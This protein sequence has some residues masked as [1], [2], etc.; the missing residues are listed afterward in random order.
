M[1]R[2]PPASWSTPA[3]S[4][5]LTFKGQERDKAAFLKKLVEFFQARKTPCYIDGDAQAIITLD[6]PRNKLAL[7]PNIQ[8]NMECEASDFGLEMNTQTEQ[9]ASVSAP[10]A[11][12]SGHDDRSNHS[13]APL[14]LQTKY[15]AMVAFDSQTSPSAYVLGRSLGEGT[16][17]TVCSATSK[18]D[19]SVVAL[20]FF[21]ETSWQAEIS[22]E[23]AVCEMLMVGEPG[24][25]H[26]VKLLDVFRNSANTVLALEHSGRTMK[27]AI[28][29]GLFR[30]ASGFSIRDAI[31]LAANVIQQLAAGLRHIHTNGII[32]SDL[33]YNNILLDEKNHVRY[34]DFGSA[35]FEHL[36]PAHSALEAVE[37][38]FPVTTLCFRAP[39]ILLGGPFGMP[40]DVW[41]VGCLVY[42][43]LTGDLPWRGHSQVDLLQ[44]MFIALGSPVENGWREA[45]GY[46]NYSTLCKG[47]RRQYIG[48]HVPFAFGDLMDSMLALDPA[49]RLNAHAVYAA[50]ARARVEDVEQ[51]CSADGA[52]V[53]FRQRRKASLHVIQEGS[54][55]RLALKLGFDAQA[56]LRDGVSVLRNQIL[57]AD[58]LAQAV[59]AAIRVRATSSGS[60][61]NE[62]IFLRPGSNDDQKVLFSLIN[63]YA[64]FL[65]ALLGS[66]KLP[67]SDGSPYQHHNQLQIAIKRA[68]FAGYAP[69]EKMANPGLGHIDQ[70]VKRQFEGCACA[71]YSCL[72][73]I[74]LQ[75]KTMNEDAGNLYVSKGSHK[76]LERA[77]AS[78]EGDIGWSPSILAK[79]GISCAAPLTPVLLNPGQAV[80]MQ[81]QTVHG[82]G[83]N[84]TD[85]DRIQIYFRVTADGR[86]SGCKIHYPAAMRNVSLELP[87]LVAAVAKKRRIG[88]M[89]A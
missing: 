49:R 11:Q 9:A 17:G 13:G 14:S 59:D 32:H 76:E 15:S 55:T 65:T 78:T 1:S 46:P 88:V 89:V 54:F 18:H 44:R 33:S 5:R 21:R 28:A 41:S 47:R 51:H 31:W 7:K 77:F 26:I 64:Q 63:K 38:G 6:S 40:C 12:A 48:E 73:G 34:A 71:N 8:R 57:S 74:C 37:G 10:V 58:E 81:Y 52:K 16:F 36:R 70:S 68:G 25:Q 84:N 66:V 45:Q 39:E 80:L 50:A 86:P 62:F 72:L 30:E 60:I 87:G 22:V 4:W 2:P 42:A 75:G 19:G 69:L 20:K 79:Y 67:G 56:Y 53:V 83:P 35:F 23:I 27:N 24:S 43:L 61:D 82:I 3:T 29:S 85:T